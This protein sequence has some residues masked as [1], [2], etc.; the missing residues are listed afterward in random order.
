MATTKVQPVVSFDRFD[1]WSGLFDKGMYQLARVEVRYAA[2]RSNPKPELAFALGMSELALRRWTQAARAF[3]RAMKS[4]EKGGADSLP[5]SAKNLGAVLARVRDAN[6]LRSI[7]IP[8]SINFWLESPNRVGLEDTTPDFS[9]RL[10]GRIENVKFVSPL[11][12]D[13]MKELERRAG[14][15]SYDVFDLKKQQAGQPTVARAFSKHRHESKR[16][17][18]EHAPPPPRQEREKAPIRSTE[19]SEAKPPTAMPKAPAPVAP[20]VAAFTP[21]APLFS[22]SVFDPTPPTKPLPPPPI[23]PADQWSKWENELYQLVLQGRFAE[24]V[25]RANNAVDRYP[26]S[27]RLREHQAYVLSTSGDTGGAVHSWIATWKLANDAG[28]DDR[29]DAAA[30]KALSLVWDDAP[31]LASIARQLAD[32]GKPA[33]LRSVLAAAAERLLA[34]GRLAAFESIGLAMAELAIKDAAS[35]P[36]AQR[37]VSLVE[38]LTGED[39]KIIARRLKDRLKR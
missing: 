5:P 35:H 13:S 36:E 31:Q 39:A 6:D 20:P 16:H 14:S 2:E 10:P 17:Q 29:A 23:N 7:P 24:A 38:R 21:A 28:A 3:I 37:V 32:E 12:L 30:R 11:N 1:K 33:V 25:E 27:S 18:T 4:L 8:R 34:D 15:F 9:G 26:A 19:W 22:K